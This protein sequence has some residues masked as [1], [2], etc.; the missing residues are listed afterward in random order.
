MASFAATVYAIYSALQIKSA[1]VGWCFK[2]QLIAP[3]PI[4][5][6]NPNINL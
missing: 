5:N 1:T 4:L 3:L 2:D 6:I